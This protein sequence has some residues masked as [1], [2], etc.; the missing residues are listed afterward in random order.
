MVLGKKTFF[1]EPYDKKQSRI[2]RKKVDSSTDFAFTKTVKKRN[3]C[4]IYPVGTLTKKT[5]FEP[6]EL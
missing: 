6:W 5:Y 1:Q 3:F 2:V 4:L